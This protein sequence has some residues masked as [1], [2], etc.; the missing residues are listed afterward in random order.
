[1][2]LK[3]LSCL[4]FLFI[5]WLSL[6]GQIEVTQRDYAIH[7]RGML[8]NTVYNTGEIAQVWQRQIEFKVTVPYMKWPGHSRTVIDG[9]EYD[10]HNNS[11]GGSIHI[12][13]NY[14]G[15]TGVLE[16]EGRLGA[17][18]GGVGKAEPEP[19]FGVWSFPVSM[20]SRTNYPLLEDGTL[21]P[22]FDPEEAE[23]ISKA[24]WNTNIGIQVQRTT[25]S[26][27]YP[28]YDDIL[29]HEYKLI[30]NG[31]YYDL[32]KAQLLQRDTTLVDVLVSFT[33]GITPSQ[34]GSSRNSDNG[35]WDLYDKYYSPSSFFDHHY[36]LQYNQWT[37][38]E[39]DT[40][41]AGWP[42][43]ILQNFLDFAR[44]GK[45]GGGLLSPQAAGFCV[46]YYD[47]DKLSVMDTLNTENSQ[48]EQYV[49][50]Q[51]DIP[52]KG[53]DGSI[54]DLGPDMK[55]KQPYFI[56]S[57]KDPCQRPKIWEKIANFQRRYG[58]Y[59]ESPEESGADLP[60]IWI[61]RSIPWD[62]TDVND[63][64]HP[65]RGI[66]FGLYYMEPGDEIEI[67]LAEVVGYGA[68][69]ESEVI[70]GLSNQP[71]L[72]RKGWG[73]DRPVS[74]E[75]Q[76]VTENYVADFGIPD[77][78]NS[79]VVNV[80]D[81]AHKAFELYTGQT[82]PHWSEW[83]END[84][85]CWP[86]KNTKDGVYRIPVP[87]PAPVITSSN[88]DT[89]TVFIKWDRYVEDFE[90][91]YPEHVNGSLQKFEIYRAEAKMGPWKLVGSIDK[92]DVDSDGAYTFVDD[93]KTF[94][95]EE[96]K[97]YSV[98]SVM[99]NGSTSGKTNIVTHKK[100]I[101]P[102]SELKKVHVVPNPFVVSSGFEGLG[103]E[104]MLG[105]YGLPKECTIYIF[106]FAGQ[107]VFEIEH[108]AEEYSNNWE[109][110][111]RNNQDLASGMYFYVVKI[112]EGEK[113]TGKFLVIK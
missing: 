109:Q 20:E 74:V 66:G 9:L 97:Y 56:Y 33:Y 7:D 40:L 104:K 46:L 108:K 50:R 77:Y 34:L 47:T 52:Y 16:E 35:Y 102:A 101:G 37:N 83:N 98:I 8:H 75:D 12:T 59:Y 30:N 32:E 11:F 13:A 103:A 80:Q 79:D 67:T 63:L 5:T 49:D 43:P 41:K 42:E 107:L 69:T 96:T 54:L 76:I 94:Y 2:N 14:K 53:E 28:D 36:W 26:W 71:K 70:G 48:S 100:S 1:M 62:S 51:L 68:D 73:C 85:P 81:V 110:I 88:T 27:S 23:Q 82:I 95:V 90:V 25:R 39:G 24:V 112:P 105:I 3:K 106:S 91:R 99:D 55:I 65:T 72:T 15:D 92:G 31:I 17:F 45:N 86:E 60:D 111:T 22:D 93:D 78:V 87:A 44:T 19:A 84:P 10:G 38:Q 64:A 4:L 57:G 113:Y 18:C 58:A 21:N 29:V 89:G 6:Y 61:G